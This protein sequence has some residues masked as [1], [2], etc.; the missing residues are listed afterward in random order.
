MLRNRKFIYLLSFVL[1]VIL[2]FLVVCE[3][4]NPEAGTAMIQKLLGRGA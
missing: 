3:R 2:C 1:F 4:K